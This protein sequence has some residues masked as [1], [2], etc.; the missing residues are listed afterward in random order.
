MN[1]RKKRVVHIST[2]HSAL[3]PR[4]RQ[5]QL[6][7]ISEAGMEAYFI[8]ADPTA[9]A[10]ED[11]VLV[12]R[13]ANRRR[14]RVWRMSLLALKAVCRALLI[15]ASAYHLHDPELL[16]WSFLLLLRG[17]P[18]FYDIHEDYCL[19]MQ[20]K[21]YLPRWSRRTIG[22]VV[23]LFEKVFSLHCH[24]I[25]AEHSYAKRFP[26]AVPILNYPLRSLLESGSSLNTETGH[27]LY[28]GYI[29]V[30]RGGLNL[31]S[32]ARELPDV[33]ITLV[34]RCFP[35]VARHMRETAGAGGNRLHIVGVD[36]YVPF[37]EICSYYAKKMWTAGIVL[38]P[39]LP[40]F[41]EK[42][43]TKFFE[44]MAFGLPIIASDFPAWRRLISDQGVGICVDP[45]NPQAVAAAVRR[46]RGNPS[47]AEEMGRRGRELVRQFYN[48][49]VQAKRLIELYKFY[50]IN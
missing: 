2:V 12:R 40:H 39:D 37:H 19:A 15:Q 44:F 22:G 45:E 25:I 49:E 41:K 48:W 20:K 23:A 33:E 27:L 21:F 38:I 32:V 50:I 26:H 8:T 18:I 47:E 5:K 10:D 28:T 6:K 1:T 11:G 36:R 35:N 46:L 16:P 3:D 29:T 34:G 17:V 13:V 9:E 31:A 4:I 42:Q 30:E 43:L 24:H 7:S 14:G